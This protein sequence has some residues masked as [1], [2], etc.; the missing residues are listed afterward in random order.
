MVGL[1]LTRTPFADEECRRFAQEVLD[2]LQSTVGPTRFFAEYNLV[3]KRAAATRLER[4]RK[5][6]FEVS[7]VGLFYDKGMDIIILLSSAS[8][9]LNSPR[10]ADFI[11]GGGVGHYFYTQNPVVHTCS[12]V[13]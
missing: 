7:Y 13:L 12:H 3:Q 4:K 8:D 5:L 6:A 2:L 11:A 9:I 1:Q 10:A